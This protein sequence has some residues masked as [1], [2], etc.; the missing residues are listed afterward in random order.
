MRTLSFF[1]NSVGLW[2][3]YRA[4]ECNIFPLVVKGFV[5]EGSGRIK[6]RNDTIML[7]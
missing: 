3:W 6:L 5:V 1:D 7:Q 4:F 2:F